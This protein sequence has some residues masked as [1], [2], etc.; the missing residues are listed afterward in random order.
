MTRGPWPAR[1][2]P[3]CTGREHTKYAFRCAMRAS[4]SPATG[5]GIGGTLRPLPSADRALRRVGIHCH[6]MG[7]SVLF[8]PARRAYTVVRRTTSCPIVEMIATPDIALGW[9]LLEDAERLVLDE[10]TGD[11]DSSREKDSKRTVET[12]E[13]DFTPITFAH[14]AVDSKRRRPGLRDRRRLEH[15]VRD[16]REVGRKPGNV[17]RIT[18]S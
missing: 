3:S 5:E 8:W 18:E 2:L 11:F 15:R 13:R 1:A 6:S 10:S 7:S 12:T 17:R 9:T 16:T 14:G 4:D